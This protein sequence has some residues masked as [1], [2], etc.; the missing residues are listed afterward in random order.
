MKYLTDLEPEYEIARERLS[1][2]DYKQYFELSVCKILNTTQFL[3]KRQDEQNCSF[4]ITKSRSDL[5]RDYENVYV[6]IRVKSSKKGE[7]EYV[8]KRIKFIDEWL[9]DENMRTYTNYVFQPTFKKNGSDN[10]HV[11]NIFNGFPLLNFENNIYRNEDVDFILNHIKT[12]VGE[13]FYDYV[14]DYLTDIIMEPQIKK[15]QC[16]IFY[17]LKGVG[18]NS[19]TDMFQRLIGLEFCNETSNPEIDSIGNFTSGRYKKLL[20]VVDESNTQENYRND[21]RLK[22][23]ISSKLFRC[24]DKHEKVFSAQSY[25]R[26]ILTTNHVNC[27]RITKDNRRF[28]LIPCQNTLK[29]NL[30]H[31]K[32]YYK[33]IDDPYTLY[34]V[35]N[36]LIKRAEGREIDVRNFPKCSISEDIALSNTEMIYKFLNFVRSRSLSD[37][38]DGSSS[39]VVTFHNS[40]IY[41][42]YRDMVDEYKLEKSMNKIAFDRHISIYA[43]SENPNKI[44]GFEKKN[45]KT[46]ENSR[47][48]HYEIDFNCLDEVLSE[49]GF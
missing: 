32:K 27:V 44:R 46:N 10:P 31:F 7:E 42:T 25:E 21:D 35:F 43:Q 14:L 45:I 24:N 6:F 48:I 30:D 8:E 40:K 33:L 18:K 3:V 23:L 9:K 38:S 15:E 11:L 36:K 39:R 19:L 41:Q 34:G 13:N 12:I 16:L 20:I 22:D 4:Y 37:L 2:S 1:Y 26:I 5:I 28:V 49:M 17:A 47:S 29:G